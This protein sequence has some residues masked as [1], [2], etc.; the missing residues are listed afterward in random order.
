MT[1]RLPD[2]P[3]W[4]HLRREAK[5]LLKYLRQ[6]YAA[7][8]PI[9][10][11]LQRFS[12]A[13]DA[14]IVA[15]DVKLNEVQFALALDYGFSSWNALKR[16]VEQVSVTKRGLPMETREIE[17]CVDAGA[18]FY[19]EVIADAEHMEVVDNGLYEMMRS[20][21]GVNNLC[22]VYNIRL[23][24]LSDEEMRRAIQEIKDLNVHTWWPASERVQNVLRGGKEPE[25][26]DGELYGI[27]TR[28]Q[29][30]E[31]PPAPDGIEVRRVR[32]R[33]EFEAWCELDN[34]VEHGGN[35]HIHPRN[36]YHLLANGRLRC[37]LGYVDG[38]AVTTAAILDNEGVGSLEFMV[39]VPEH[40]R[41]GFA[42]AVCLF[43][44]RDAFRAGV[45]T[46]SVRT[47]GDGRM[48]GRSLGFRYIDPTGVWNIPQ[49]AG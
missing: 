38:S 47:I 49:S 23:D 19:L 13:S 8:C 48:L 11:N 17:Q 1:A 21:G 45:K 2:R 35:V 43:A 10:R 46:V 14:D 5:S 34:R 40:R 22:V 7:A 30:P 9:L 20:R 28:D 37:Y 39:T 26:W 24:H 32:S 3:D 42:K 6:G 4:G 18:N 33:E 16:H 15:S 25:F 29:M 27:M 12:H 44:L 36:H 41:R 31:Y